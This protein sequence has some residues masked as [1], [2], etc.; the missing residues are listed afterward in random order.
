MCI[1]SYSSAETGSVLVPLFGRNGC[2]RVHTCAKKSFFVGELDYLFA[3]SNWRAF[4]SAECS[5]R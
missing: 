5:T 4:L 3:T 2:I 1:P